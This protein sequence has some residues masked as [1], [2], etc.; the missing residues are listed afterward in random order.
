M[1]V[2][3][4][5]VEEA[6]CVNV[7]ELTTTIKVLKIHEGVVKLGIIGPQ[8]VRVDRLEVRE[9]MIAEEQGGES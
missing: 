5:K 2:L 4:R 3:S 6:I 9:R 1:L 7:G 8:G